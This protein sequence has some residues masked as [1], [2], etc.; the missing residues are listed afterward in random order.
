M[1][2]SVRTAAAATIA[3]AALTAPL[4]GAAHA[5]GRG[6]DLSTLQAKC[7]RQ[8]DRRTRPLVLADAAVQHAPALTDVHRM[9]LGA[10]ISSDRANVTTTRAAIL[11]AT[12]VDDLKTQCTAALG[13]LQFVRT[14]TAKVALTIAADRAVALDAEVQSEIDTISTALDTLEGLGIDVTDLRAALAE[15]Q[16]S[17]DDLV[18][19]LD[20]LGDA[21][22]TTSVGDVDGALREDAQLLRRARTT[23][24]D[25]FGQLGALTHALDDG[26]AGG[27]G[28]SI[29]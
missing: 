17:L 13:N 21:I 11:A 9:L 14:D 5:R 18:T 15:V 19:S 2:L 6:P 27:G 10:I 8:L 24:R 22:I 3:A 16:A 25:L 29:S 1:R 12:T 26:D 4:A 20:G 23:R 28:T 7:V